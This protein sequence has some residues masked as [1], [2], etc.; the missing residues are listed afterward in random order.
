MKVKIAKP[1]NHNDS[2]FTGFNIEWQHSVVKKKKKWH[3]EYVSA[4]IVS[5]R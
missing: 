3:S 1:V 2:L 5:Q 4:N